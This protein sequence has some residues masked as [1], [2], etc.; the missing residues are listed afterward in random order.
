MAIEFHFLTLRGSDKLCMC[1][2]EKRLVEATDGPKAI[3]IL[4]SPLSGSVFAVPGALRWVERRANGPNLGQC[5][6]R[7]KEKPKT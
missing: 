5:S 7:S 4:S 1:L 3:E 2:S 6:H